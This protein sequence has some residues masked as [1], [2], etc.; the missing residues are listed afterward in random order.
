M[1]VGRRHTVTAQSKQVLPFQCR[2]CNHQA[3]AL[4]VG[5]GQGQGN[6]PYMLDES[7]AKQRAADSSRRAADD[8]ARLTLKLA[9]CPKCH[10]RD[11]DAL[12]SLKTKAVATMVAMVVGLF[13]LG[14]FF[15]SL[16][17]TG[18]G[19][20]IFGVT[21]LFAAWFVWQKSSW[22]WTTIDNRV[23]F[24]PDKGAS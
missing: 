9:V 20:W 18:F 8:N 6:S 11:E 24:L 16:K 13:L 15:D 3:M 4:V 17:N 14:L 19:V 21:G 5:V 12:R 1:Y 23:A 10:R 2:S 22:K 7:G